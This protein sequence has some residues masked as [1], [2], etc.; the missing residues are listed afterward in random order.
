M[1]TEYHGHTRKQRPRLAIA[2]A[3]GFT[4]LGAIAFAAFYVLHAGT[5]LLGAAF[6]VAFGGLAVGLT[7]WSRHLLSSG[8]YVEEHEGFTS[9][10]TEQQE[11][12]TELAEIAKPNR[13][14]LLAM[15]SLAVLSI[16]GAALFPLRS[17]MQPRGEHVLQQLRETAWRAGGLRLVDSAKRPV[18]LTDVRDDT[19]VIVE[20]EGRT[21]SGDTATFVVRLDPSR[22]VSPPPAGHLSGVVAYSLLCTHAGCPVGLFEQSTGRMLCPCHQS[23]FNLLDGG[24]AVAG[25]AARSLP[26]LPISVDGDGFLYATGD[27]TDPPG[28]GYWS[29]P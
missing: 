4:I 10:P 6:A 12:A 9:G 20:P 26:G 18:R 16:G 3:F 22:F 21:R 8:E 29:R 28:P 5:Q 19:I 1:S 17:L 2:T 11:L 7:V 24:R 14:G 25:P 23:V 27:F 15:L 13:R